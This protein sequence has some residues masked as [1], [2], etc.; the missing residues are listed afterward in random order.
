MKK[1]N[2]QLLRIIACFGVFAVHMVPVL[3]VEQSS[4]WS[5]MG[6]GSK[7]VY[8]F[9]L[10]SG[11]V[12][13]VSLDKTEEFNWVKYYQGR[14]I[15][16]LP[17]YY[18]VILYWFILHQYIL[19]D[20]P[21]GVY[22]EW[23]RYA[24][25]VNKTLPSSDDFWANIGATWT[26]SSF[27][28]F[29]VLVPVIRKF[30]QTF[31]SALTVWLGLFII[32]E[33]LVRFFTVDEAMSICCLHY[34]LFG[35]VAFYAV[36]EGKKDSY[37]LICELGT[38]LFL[39]LRGTWNNTFWLMIFGVLLV[40]TEKISIRNTRIARLIDIL[41][42]HSYDVYL[43]HPIILEWISKLASDNQGLCLGAG[44][45]GTALTVI[46]VHNL[47]EKPLQHKLTALIM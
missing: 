8:L 19:C 16:I 14:M 47:I 39:F 20:T 22:S 31:K 6:Y 11:F 4:V 25:L 42:E 37:F 18:L 35:I 2:I 46:I 29:Y 27:A 23:L 21:G 7:G 43:I 41:D 17:L 34:F 13:Y 26:M 10:I 3:G 32:S 40:T 33:I 45:L 9:F 24:F 30:V 44:I 36:K 12:T 15:R 1:Q 5:K 28:L 38:L